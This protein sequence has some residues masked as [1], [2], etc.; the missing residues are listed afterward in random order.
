MLIFES[1]STHADTA[2]R[3]FDVSILGWELGPD[4]ELNERRLCLQILY[5]HVGRNI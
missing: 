5:I 3:M 2:L 4:A 1:P